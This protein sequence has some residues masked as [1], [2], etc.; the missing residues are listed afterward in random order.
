MERESECESESKGT[1]SRVG[2]LER[3]DR[4]TRSCGRPFAC[5][6]HSLAGPPHVRHYHVVLEVAPCPRIVFCP[7]SDI[8]K[9]C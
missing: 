6:W 7:F 9:L 5:Y 1:E 2:D 3:T 4:W 8:L